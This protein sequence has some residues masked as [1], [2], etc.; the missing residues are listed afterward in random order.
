MVTRR[1]GVRLCRSGSAFSGPA[2]GALSALE[3]QHIFDRGRRVCPGG[4]ERG[5][6]RHSRQA[7]RGRGR[8]RAAVAPLGFRVVAACGGG[9]SPP[10]R[11]G[12]LRATN[13]A[14]YPTGP[15]HGC[16]RIRHG[17]ARV[18]AGSAHVVRGRLRADLAG[19]TG[20]FCRLYHRWSSP[21]GGHALARGG[22]PD[23]LLP[24]FA[25][26]LLAYLLVY[27][28]SPATFMRATFCVFCP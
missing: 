18:L 6:T 1:A 15:N 26:L 24:A 21:R 5:R 11:C 17:G 25:A 23:R 9:R 20:S 2:R 14:N 13:A 19:G 4:S 22:V 3:R 7:S 28:S 27:S 8:A 10:C 16:E 12:L